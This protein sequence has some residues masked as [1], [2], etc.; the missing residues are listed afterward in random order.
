MERMFLYGCFYVVFTRVYVCACALV[1]DH[2]SNA[3]VAVSKCD[4]QIN[5]ACDQTTVSHDWL[6]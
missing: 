4:C 6:L 2:T 3:D 5:I 1:C